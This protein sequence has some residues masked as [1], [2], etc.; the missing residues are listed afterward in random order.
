MMFVIVSAFAIVIDS[1][2]VV[3]TSC[4]KKPPRDRESSATSNFFSVIVLGLIYE[5]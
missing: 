1:K 2:Y 4:M 3:L 5:N